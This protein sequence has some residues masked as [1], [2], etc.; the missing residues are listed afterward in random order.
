MVQDVEC[1]HAT[2]KEVVVIVRF[3]VIR[4]VNAHSD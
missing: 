2:L 1:L 3:K 4:A